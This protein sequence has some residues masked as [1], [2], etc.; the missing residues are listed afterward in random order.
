MLD[1]LRR[2]LSAHEVKV[3]EPILPV[4]KPV[5]QAMG[6]NSR[7]LSPKQEVAE[8]IESM[9]ECNTPLWV[10]WRELSAKVSKT[11]DFQTMLAYHNAADKME[12]MVVDRNL[13][14]KEYEKAGEEGKAI[15]LYEA[16]VRDCFDGSHPYERLRIIYTY[17]KKYKDAIRVCDAYISN[18]QQDPK[19]KEKY[20]QVIKDLS[21][22]LNES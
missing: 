21:A 4:A 6:S 15:R 1:W 9:K 16:N 19:L 3:E 2:L 14:G 7:K 5:V 22:R 18:G 20:I 12:K 17:K 13:K 11:E 8:W 10:I